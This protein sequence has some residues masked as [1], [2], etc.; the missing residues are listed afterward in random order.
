MKRRPVAPAL[1]LAATGLV[2][3]PATGD[4]HDLARLERLSERFDA[5][6]AAGD[7]AAIADVD[8][9]VRRAVAREPEERRVRTLESV[10]AWASLAGRYDPK[11]LGER[12]AILDGFLAA[13]RAASRDD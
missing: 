11:S 10:R 7:T 1:V 4:L 6:R 12:R 2:L 8:V 3:A 5:A 13:A 9:A